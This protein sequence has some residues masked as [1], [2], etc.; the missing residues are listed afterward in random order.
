MDLTTQNITTSLA[1]LF[2]EQIET[3]P[4][5]GLRQKALEA[6][7]S[8]G[9]PEKKTE[10]YKFTPVKRIIEKNID[11]SNINIDTAGRS[12]EDCQKEFYQDEGNHLVFLNGVFNEEYSK[13]FSP[14]S[15]LEIKSINQKT[16]EGAR[17]LSEKLGQI[18]FKND[19]FALLN[20]AG[21]TQGLLLET[22][23][24]THNLPVYIYHFHGTSFQGIL[25][26]RVYVKSAE[27]SSLRVYEKTFRTGTEKHFINSIIETRI[28]K[29]AELRWTKL[30]NYTDNDYVIDGFYGIQDRDSRAYTNTFSFKGALVR[31]N[32]NISQ[33]GENCETYM[34]GLYQLGHH[35]HVDNNTGVDHKMPN[36]YSNELYKGIVDEN[37]HAVFNGK[38]YVRP[39]AQKT[40][41]FQSNENILLSEQATVNSK[42]QLEIWADDVKCSHGCTTGQL[43][44][45]AIFY[46]RSRGI[47]KTR[48]KALMLNAFASEALSEIKNDLIKEEIDSI[49][50][51]RL[52]S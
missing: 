44:E 51:S 23:K 29:N 11:F 30:Q 31:N 46:L 3:D 39:Q 32:L 42:P 50:L 10:A 26:P 8:L 43:D 4:L 21:F 35:S 7:I 41:A 16:F 2:R 15:D 38:I 25:S 49:I 19:P 45:E 27:G 28:E 13:I 47:S 34:H 18:A 14:S 6:F 40:N 52:G 36:S 5:N 22:K 33:E 9:L 12:K 48:A 20:L 1:D 37:A 24:N 17:E